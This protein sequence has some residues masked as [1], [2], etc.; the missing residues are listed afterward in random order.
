MSNKYFVDG[1][2]CLTAFIDNEP[3]SRG[4][5]FALNPF[6]SICGITL[7]AEDCYPLKCLVESMHNEIWTSLAG[8]VTT[9]CGQD[10]STEEDLAGLEIFNEP[11]DFEKL[12]D[13]VMLETP[14]IKAFNDWLDGAPQGEDWDHGDVSVDGYKAAFEFFEERRKISDALGIKITEGRHP[15][16]NTQVAELEISTEEANKRAKYSGFDIVFKDIT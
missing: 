1:T 2:K 10:I 15:G 8:I 7:A 11:S 16:D 3:K 6:N 5:L 12:A 9:I 13:F 14:I 4:D